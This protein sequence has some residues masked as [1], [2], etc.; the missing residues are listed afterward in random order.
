MW[1]LF[2][3][4]NNDMPLCK[5]TNVIIIFEPLPTWVDF[6]VFYNLF[7][8][9]FKSMLSIIP[10]YSLILRASGRT[11]CGLYSPL[12]YLLIQSFCYCW[13]LDWSTLFL[14]NNLRTM[15]SIVFSDLIRKIFGPSLIHPSFFPVPL[16][17][18]NIWSSQDCTLSSSPFGKLYLIIYVVSA[19]L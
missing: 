14:V 17:L 10:Q 16:L 9:L 5:Y 7:S 12:H 8:T 13:L 1:I 19:M 4:Y 6:C 15:K 18:M 11:T 3:K 2:F